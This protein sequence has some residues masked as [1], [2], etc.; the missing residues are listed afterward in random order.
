MRATAIAPLITLVFAATVVAQNPDL[1]PADQFLREA[2]AV[3]TRSQEVWHR[4]AY[5]ERST[6]LHMNPFGRMGTGGVN[7]YD[8]R[9]SPNP[10]LTYRRLISRN[11][12]PLSDDE[13]RRQDAEYKTRAARIEDA[14]TDGIDHQ[15]EEEM[16]ARKRAQM[17][18]EDVVNTMQFDVARRE[19][20]NG[21]PVIIVT[22]AAK[23]NARPATREGQLASVFRGELSIDEATKEITDVKA[24]AVRSVAFGGFIAKVYEG[25]EVTVVRRSV[26]PGVWMPTR[27]TLSGNFRALFRTAKIDHVVEWYDYH[28]MP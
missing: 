12:V 6:E 13:L 1:P 2:R 16:L 7:V 11:G 8:V 23:P 20:R 22:L 19:I 25:T 24:V 27:L 3:F 18:V 17:M 5:T 14:G 26:D 10:K 9:P 21:V 4:Y 15:R 28:R